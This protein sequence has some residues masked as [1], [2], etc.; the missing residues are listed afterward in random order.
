MRSACLV[1]MQTISYISPS[2]SCYQSRY[3]THL[4][5]HTV[6][7][8]FH[9][10]LH[11]CLRT[12]Q[13][14]STLCSLWRLCALWSFG[15]VPFSTKKMI[16]S[17]LYNNGS[18]GG[19]HCCQSNIQTGVPVPLPAVKLTTRASA[20]RPM[21]TLV[22]TLRKTHFEN[23]LQRNLSSTACICIVHQLLYIQYMYKHVQ[24]YT[25]L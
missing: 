7:Q 21:H 5:L 4:S 24:Y 14:R 16:F 3:F 11:S 23:E 10:P 15:T 17:P 2:N 8:R 9:L 6:S 22:V 1:C 12:T 25:L 20:C 19:L 13:Q 18:G